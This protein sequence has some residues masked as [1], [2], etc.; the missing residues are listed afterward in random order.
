MATFKWPT[1]TKRITSKFR[2]S[3]R[4][5]HSGVDIAEGGYQPIYAIAEGTVTKSYTSD[6]YGEVIF[7]KHI[8]HGDTY[9]SV[10]AHMKRG[11]RTVFP[12]DR[13]RKG[14]QIGIMGNTGHSTGKHLHFELH[15][16]RWN[17]AKSNAVDPLNYLE[18]NLY[19]ASLTVDGKWGNATTT[20]LQKYLATTVDGII[21]DQVHNSVTN[22]FYGTTIDFGSGKKGSMV[23]KALQRL[24]G[25]NDD[26][27]LGPITI[28]ALQ[29]YLGTVYDKK[30]SRPSLVV[31]ELQ[32]RLN[33][34]TL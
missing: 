33:K 26:G 11:S 6:S 1:D 32:R 15:K 23:I 10:C 18:K 34:G 29:K 28:G 14:Q 30:L 12:G 5:D 20:A 17:Y 16:G 2:T 27:L 7:I 4:P 9:E 3:S 21:S 19:E 31:K 24:I 8:V 22:A 25:V 13:V